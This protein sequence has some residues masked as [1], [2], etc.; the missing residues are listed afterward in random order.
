MASTSLSERAFWLF[1]CFFTSFI[2]FSY[3]GKGLCTIALVGKLSIAE[4]S[5]SYVK[6][7]LL[8]KSL[9]KVF[10]S[11]FLNIKATL[12]MSFPCLEITSNA[13][14][15]NERRFNSL[16]HSLDAFKFIP[17][18]SSEYLQFIT[19]CAH[20]RISF[21]CLISF[22]FLTLFTCK[23]EKVASP[24]VPI[25]TRDE[26]TRPAIVVDCS[27]QVILSYYSTDA[28]DSFPKY[29]NLLYW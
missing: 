19:L 24:I 18:I 7:V 9:T 25:A 15:S 6:D 2:A 3:S 29:S 4:I 20:A 14:A 21:S 13:S 8:R 27:K 16:S 12:L 10:K 22:C 11:A 23:K 26:I 28:G 17:I 5:L 1:L